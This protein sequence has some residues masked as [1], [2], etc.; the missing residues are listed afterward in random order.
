M[1]DRFCYII[2]IAKIMGDLAGVDDIRTVAR[3]KE[4]DLQRGISCSVC[5]AGWKLAAGG[6]V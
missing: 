6:E 4:R 5:P 2:G 1:V 3:E